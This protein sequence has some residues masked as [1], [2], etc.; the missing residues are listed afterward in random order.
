MET[1]MHVILLRHATRNTHELGDPPLNVTG[2]AQAQELVESLNTKARIPRPSLILSS[3]KK[4]ARETLAPVAKSLG[5]SVVIDERLDERHQ[6]ESQKV[7]EARVHDLLAS[8]KSR[9]TSCI[10]LCSHFDWLETAFVSL[11]NLIDTSPE[12]SATSFGW[13]TAEF[14]I[15]EFHDGK[16][17]LGPTPRAQEFK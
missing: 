15:F 17:A 1:E 14:K 6:N 5:I 9:G 3:P 11:I 13:A 8:L 10:L 12:S 4:R 16:W 2:Q 7:F